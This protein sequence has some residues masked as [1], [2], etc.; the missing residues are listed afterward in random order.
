MSLKIKKKD[1]ETYAVLKDEDSAPQIIKDV[2]PKKP[3]KGCNCEEE[4]CKCECE[5]GDK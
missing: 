2:E 4:Q 1:G 5:E 3:K